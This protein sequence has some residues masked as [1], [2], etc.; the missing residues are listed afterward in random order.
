[1]TETS[2]INGPAT[3]SDSG[4]DMVSPAAGVD[5]VDG[6]N[7][8]RLVILGAVVGVVVLA[9]AAFL[10]LHKGSSSTPDQTFV[11]RSSHPVAAPS[12]AS[13]SGATKGSSKSGNGSG[14]QSQPTKLP[15]KAK[16]PSVRDPFKALVLP[17]VTTSGTASSTTTVTAPSA[18]PTA[19]VGVQPSQPVVQPVPQPTS[20]STTTP[21]HGGKTTGAPLWIQLMKTHLDKAT[22]KVGYAHHKFRKFVVQAPKPSS[23]QGTVFDKVFALI[24]IQNGAATIQIGDDTPFD[25]TTG[26]SHVV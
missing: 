26:V 16:R 25:L 3:S 9:A 11:P 12:S 4:I 7:R 21:G 13:H 20:S 24:G 14:H 15:K 5:D 6:G 2:T 17:P 8:R 22:F 19:P 18:Q 23:Q 1:M 10:L